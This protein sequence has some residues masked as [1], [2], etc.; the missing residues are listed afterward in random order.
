LAPNAPGANI[1]NYPSSFKN[2]G[3]GYYEVIGET[4]KKETRYPRTSKDLSVKASSVSIPHTK[5][6]KTAETADKTE[7][8][9]DWTYKRILNVNSPS[10]R[11]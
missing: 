4:A 1:Y 6:P 8:E 10:T 5:P 7:V 2:P 3:P 11:T 9:A